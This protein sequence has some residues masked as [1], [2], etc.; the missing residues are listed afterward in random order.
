MGLM[1]KEAAK[2]LG[3][4]IGLFME[5]DCD[6][7]DQVAVKFLRVK[8]RLDIRKPLWWGIVV[9]VREGGVDR[10]CP[11]QYEYLPDFCYVCG[12]IG[13]TDKM[14]SKK[15]AAGDKHLLIRSYV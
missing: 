6:N 3:D 11:L 7:D 14:C 2:T 8:V 9:E 12:I 13:H 1:N 15:L 10:W 4:E 5:T